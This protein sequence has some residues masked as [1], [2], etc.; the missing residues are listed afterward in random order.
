MTSLIAPGKV[1]TPNLGSAMSFQKMT[2][3]TQ[4]PLS[5]L[6]VHEIFT[7]LLKQSLIEQ[8][9]MNN[10]TSNPMVVWVSKL[11][12]TN[13]QIRFVNQS[14]V[15]KIVTHSFSFKSMF[16]IV[17]YN[18][19]DILLFNNYFLYLFTVVKRNVYILFMHIPSQKGSHCKHMYRKI[20]KLS[21]GLKFNR[22]RDTISPIF[23]RCQ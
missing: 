6:H 5:R 20:V 2:N 21:L 9:I 17:I 3:Q 10:V 22:Q 7:S 1:K 23:S 14:S 11:S 12:V 19:F 18:L 16:L 8:A 13:P 4:L 15:M